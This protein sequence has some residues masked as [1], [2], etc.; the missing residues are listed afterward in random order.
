M[1]AILIGCPESDEYR[2][3]ALGGTIYK[4]TTT[5]TTTIPDVLFT[6]NKF[7]WG[8]WISMSDGKAYNMQDQKIVVD[9]KPYWY[10]SGT[11]ESSDNLVVEHLGKFVK[12]SDSVILNGAIPYFRQGGS[13]IEYKLK[14]VGINGGRAGAT[15]TPLDNKTVTATSQTYASYTN[16][17]TTDAYGEVTLKAPTVNDVQT[18]TVPKESGGSIIVP[19]VKVETNGSNMGTIAV[20]QEGDYT[21]KVYGNVT[22]KDNGYM[23]AGKDYNMT[24]VIKNISD[25][26]AGTSFVKV[27]T[28]DDQ[29]N[30]DSAV[31]E[32]FNVKAGQVVAALAPGMEKQIKMTVQYNNIADGYIDTGLKVSI[33]NKDA[34]EE[35]LWE[36]YVP[37]RFFK[38]QYHWTI[39][40]DSTENNNN[41]DLHGFLIYPDKSS[42]YFYVND[43]SHKTIIVPSFKTNEDYLLVFSGATFGE[44]LAESSA[45]FYTVQ[46]GDNAMT[47]DK[48]DGD[49][50]TFG[51]NNNTEGSAF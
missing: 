14:I 51:G 30:F 11:D 4:S 25:V 22:N 33:E 44:T 45:M 43:K 47:I 34:E 1:I 42:Q 24:L 38:G 20:V 9:N 50:V 19:G 32:E 5:T 6:A 3:A 12:Q 48:T 7:F 49:S 18:I 2:H 10:K 29:L 15:S 36:D 39:N 46:E 16:S 28:E 21:L 27:S 17:S 35:E 8:T 41:A 31:G 40:A 13:N 23:Y 37:L 26:L